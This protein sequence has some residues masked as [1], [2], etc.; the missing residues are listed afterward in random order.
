VESRLLGEKVLLGGEWWQRS[1]F[2]AEFEGLAL[3]VDEG[4]RLRA[5][6]PEMTRAAR[7]SELSLDGT[8]EGAP[9]TIEMERDDKFRLSGG[10]KGMVFAGTNEAQAFVESFMSAGPTTKLTLDGYADG[11]RIRVTLESGRVTLVDR[12][13]GIPRRGIDMVKRD[14]A[15]EVRVL[16]ATLE[17]VH[18]KLLGEDGL[19]PRGQRFEAEFEALTL[20][21]GDIEPLVNLLRAALRARP[22]SDL[23]LNG[24][25]EDQPFKAKLDLDRKGRG[26][27]RLEGFVFAS[28]AEV[29]PFL[30]RFEGAEGLRE[31]TLTG[32]AAGHTLRRTLGRR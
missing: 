5:L 18:E 7:D 6:L 4:S 8:L 14:D 27:L 10:V 13:A 17:D 29:D 9:F 26:R 28:E 15:L 1:R 20:T 30:A 21:A 12:G 22:R 24:T 23:E 25:L 3:R 31:L 19:V 32:S 2:N 16:P 11:R